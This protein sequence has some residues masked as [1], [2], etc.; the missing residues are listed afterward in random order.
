MSN[1]RPITALPIL[2]KIPNQFGFR[3]TDTALDFFSDNILKN[4]ENGL[5]TASVFLDFSR[6]L[7]TVDHLILLR[8]LKSF[9][10]DNNSLN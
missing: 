4:V 2:S 1:Y 5:V 3:S 7:D 10:L 6:A 8:K 9:G